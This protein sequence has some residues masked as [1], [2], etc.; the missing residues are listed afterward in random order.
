MLGSGL[1]ILVAVILFYVT[2]DYNILAHTVSALA[3]GK[4][5]TIYTIFLSF[6]ALSIFILGLGLSKV[7]EQ[8]FIS[9][10]MSFFLIFTIGV[11]IL[12][13]FKMDL[14]LDSSFSNWELINLAGKIHFLDT[15]LALFF[16][17]VGVSFLVQE[18]KKS[19]FWR[20]LIPYTIFVLA[21]GFVLG[22]IWFVLFVFGFGYAWK[23]IFQK[24]I[25]FD[26]IIWCFVLGY[27]LYKRSKSN[28]K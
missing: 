11:L 17:P 2:P 19:G 4:F 13:V 20:R 22:F 6:F 21:S 10:T 8:K 25:I 14:L 24:A 15:V 16:F 12:A 7:L 5:G 27:W 23:G 9:K 1:F 28:A 18:F 3:H 26:L